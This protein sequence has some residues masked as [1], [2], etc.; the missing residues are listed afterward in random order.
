[1]GGMIW[2]YLLYSGVGNG[3]IRYGAW[4]NS[5]THVIMYSHYFWTSFG[6]KNPFKRYIT[7]WQISQFYS[8]LAHAFIVR[9]LE[10][11]PCNA[12]AWIQICYQITMVYLFTLKMSYVPS[13]TPELN[14]KVVE[15]EKDINATK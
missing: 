11:G 6:L 1:M 3:T 7:L 15:P 2:G 4:V 10:T 12:F 9:F 8:C 14:A 5:L 13:C